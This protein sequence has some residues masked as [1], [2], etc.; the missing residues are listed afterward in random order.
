L[1]VILQVSDKFF[2]ESNIAGPHAPKIGPLGEQDAFR[3]SGIK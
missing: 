3:D 1:Q 2:I